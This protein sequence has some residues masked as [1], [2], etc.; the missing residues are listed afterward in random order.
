MGTLRDK[1]HGGSPPLMAT[2]LQQEWLGS[3]VLEPTP[4]VDQVVTMCE[5]QFKS[6]LDM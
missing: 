1:A 6:C 3:L 4:L 2:S 5:K